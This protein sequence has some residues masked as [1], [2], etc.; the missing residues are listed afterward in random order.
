MVGRHLFATKEYM[1]RIFWI[2]WMQILEIEH[3]TMVFSIRKE[4][5][6]EY[7]MDWNLL[8][9]KKNS[10]RNSSE[11]IFDHLTNCVF[12]QYCFWKKLISLHLIFFPI[13]FPFFMNSLKIIYLSFYS[14]WHLLD[15]FLFQILFFQDIFSR[16]FYIIVS[17]CVRFLLGNDVLFI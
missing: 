4:M 2:P 5:M 12:F 9:S 14:W 3:K 11:I 13:R 10:E 6:W 16:Y 7:K 1:S 8:I 17:F 15:W